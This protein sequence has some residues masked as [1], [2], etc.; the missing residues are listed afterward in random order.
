MAQTHEEI[1][2]KDC[3]LCKTPIT[4][5]QRF[6]NIVK[7]VYHDVQNVKKRVYGNTR[8]IEASR[9]DLRAKM[10]RLMA[11][12]PK[13][14]TGSTEYRI[15][16][17]KLWDELQHVQ[18]KR[19]NPLSVMRTDTLAVQLEMFCQLVE[20]C[21]NAY[22][23][24]HGESR[25]K[26]I[27]YMDTLLHAVKKRGSKISGQEIEEISMEIH[28]FHRLCQL[29]KIRSEGAYKMNCSKPEVKKCFD[30]AHRIAHSI[31]KFS[32]ECDMALKDA[33]ENLKKELKSAV[34]ITDA[35]RKMIVGALGFKL[36]HWYKCPNGHIYC[37]SEGG[38]AMQIG[39]CNE[40]G[41]AI[42]GSSHRLLPDNSLAS[43]MDG[44][45][46]PAWPQ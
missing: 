5:T 15:L 30:T 3:P 17:D 42:G 2:L 13:D 1:K 18:L 20:C 40:C 6:M 8:K 21:S 24:L 44:A 12:C 23:D 33:L 38:G 41:A 22:S 27:S 34:I 26:V 10:V 25:D 28:R 11:H 37:I 43:E 9:D 32:K 7:K 29:Y 19:R 36:G 45:T 39:Q 31:E 14:M 46:R 4:K 16:Y 35:E